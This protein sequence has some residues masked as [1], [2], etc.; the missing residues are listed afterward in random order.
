M[1]MLMKRILLAV[2]AFATLCCVQA[3]A[4]GFGVTAG[5][6]FNSAKIKEVK[7]DARAGWNVGVTYG[8]DLPLGF[9][10]QPALVY[11][12]KGAKIDAQVASVVQ[13]VGSLELPVSLQW[14]PDLVVA[15]PFIDV[16]P[17][18]GYS[19]FNKAELKADL[20][21]VIGAK[22]EGKGKNAFDYGLGVGAGVDLWK[23][24][25]VLRYNWNFGPLGSLKDFT[26]IDLGDLNS[27]EETFGGIAFSLAYF[28]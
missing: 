10:V 7:M 25:F 21:D 2:L 22:M 16:T 20:L 3:S 11:T 6:N 27:K 12:Q 5:M 28:F 14:G 17:F 1:T 9:S 8:V 26:D 23:L 19:L 24:R 4:Q 15:R 13:T 18:I